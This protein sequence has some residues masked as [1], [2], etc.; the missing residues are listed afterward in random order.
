MWVISFSL[1]PK[2]AHQSLH[3]LSQPVNSLGVFP[4]VAFPQKFYIHQNDNS[5][6]HFYVPGICAVFFLHNRI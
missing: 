1:G 5:N 2:P 3:P 4:R 6:Y